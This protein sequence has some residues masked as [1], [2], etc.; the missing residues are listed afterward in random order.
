M[1]VC[2][3]MICC[4][5]WCF[6]IMYILTWH[7]HTTHHDAL[8]H[9]TLHCITLHDTSQ[10][11]SLGAT[12]TRCYGLGDGDGG[13]EGCRTGGGRTAN[14][15]AQRAVYPH[16]CCGYRYRGK[17]TFDFYFKFFMIR[18]DTMWYDIMLSLWYK[19]YHEDNITIINL[20]NFDKFNREIL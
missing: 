2:Y 14:R 13:G 4:W 20:F 12:K 6:L 3:K 15:P 1:S 10:S 7:S 11:L 9:T 18:Y 19:C 16:I 8:H 5:M 17:G